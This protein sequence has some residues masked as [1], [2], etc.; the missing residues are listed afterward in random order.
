MQ[1]HIL[2]QTPIHSWTVSRPNVYIL[3]MILQMYTSVALL[4]QAPEAGRLQGLK[5]PPT[6]E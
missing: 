3:Q 6:S 2:L 1:F 4:I 5:K